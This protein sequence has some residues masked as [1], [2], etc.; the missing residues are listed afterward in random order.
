MSTSGSEPSPL[1][2]RLAPAK[3][4][5]V[6]HEIRALGAQDAAFCT[7]SYDEDHQR[8]VVYRTTQESS[9][10][11]SHYRAALPPGLE[12]VF[13]PAVLNHVDTMRLFD[14]VRDSRDWLAEQGIS[15]TV[16][17]TP[18]ITDS[19]GN[20]AIGPFEVGFTGPG[21]PTPEVIERISMY[22][23]E[24]V[25]FVRRARVNGGIFIGHRPKES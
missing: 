23:S 5:T 6:A 16:C 8:I 24:T 4:P 9:F 12:I 11:E 17:S 3:P 15:V 14:L 20:T 21:E 7:V 2:P 19:D 13:R 10:G 25:T 18:S 1:V 22:G